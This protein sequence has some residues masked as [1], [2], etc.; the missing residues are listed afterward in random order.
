MV[1]SEVPTL[2]PILRM[3]LT[4]PATGISFFS[5]ADSDIRYKSSNEHEEEALKPIT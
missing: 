4:I 5:G 1:T 3:K 2:L